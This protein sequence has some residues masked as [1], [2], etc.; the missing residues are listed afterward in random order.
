MYMVPSHYALASY[1]RREFGE[2]SAMSHTAPF[3]NVRRETRL[4][5]QSRTSPSSVQ[6]VYSQEPY[7]VTLRIYNTA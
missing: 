3:S 6:E 4:S 2:P 1:I 5:I 7:M